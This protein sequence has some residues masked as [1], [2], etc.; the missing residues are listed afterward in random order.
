MI[1][2]FI[3]TPS[4]EQ[5]KAIISCLSCLRGEGRMERQ[6]LGW[7]ISKHSSQWEGRHMESQERG[8]KS[9]GNWTEQGQ[10]H[11]IWDS[12]SW[13]QV[14]DRRCTE[15]GGVEGKGQWL[16]S[17]DG[18]EWTHWQPQGADAASNSCS[19]WGLI[20]L[21]QPELSMNTPSHTNT[22]CFLQ[23][24]GKTLETCSCGNSATSVTE[25]RKSRCL[26]NF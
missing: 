6:R 20:A 17:K 25:E 22:A 11:R 3:L 18:L 9:D 4:K 16:P 2:Y 23:W 26:H 5:S 7:D 15:L 12:S 1:K 19:V 13:K 24:A 8:G 14:E 21:L 10:S